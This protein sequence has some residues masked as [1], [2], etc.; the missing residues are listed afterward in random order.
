MREVFGDGR[1]YGDAGCAMCESFDASS[2]F[3]V[4]YKHACGSH[5]SLSNYKPVPGDGIVWDGHTAV[6]TATSSSTITYMQQ[7]AGDYYGTNNVPWHT[8]T[9]PD[10]FGSLDNGTKDA[11]CVIHETSN[12]CEKGETTTSGC[13]SGFEKACTS[14]HTWGSCECTPGATKTCVSPDCCGTCGHATQ[15]CTSSHTWST[16]VC[17][18]GC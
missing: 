13:A 10:T 17:Q 11:A 7:N 18:N 14:K 2:A 5:T 15:T 1:H 12:V 16:G 6:V 3:S 4:Y 8:S 9:S